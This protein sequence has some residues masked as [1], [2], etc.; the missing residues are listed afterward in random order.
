MSRPSA[1]I[2]HITEELETAGETAQ[3]MNEEPKTK[4][5][6]ENKDQGLF[7]FDLPERP[8][9]AERCSGEVCES[10]Q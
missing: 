10:C 6:E 5:T 1:G 3:F 7:D 9:A 2:D 8:E 4:E